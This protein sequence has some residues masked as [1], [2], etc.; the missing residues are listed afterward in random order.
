MSFRQWDVVKVRINPTDRDEHPA[1]IIS[2][3]EIAGDERTQ[4]VNVLYGSTR[5]PGKELSVRQVL[6]NGADGLDHAT[7]FEC[8]HFFQ[9]APASI[10]GSYGRVSAERRSQIK[11]KIVSLFRLA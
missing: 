11:R 9:V 4:R 3:D 2:P 6:L 1:I 7:V 8:A 5:R 10:S